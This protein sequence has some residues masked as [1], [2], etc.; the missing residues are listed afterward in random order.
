MNDDVLERLRSQP[1]F[2]SAVTSVAALQRKAMGMLSPFEKH[3]E[4]M[5]GAQRGSYRPEDHPEYWL[6]DLYTCGAVLSGIG[7]MCAL[8]VARPFGLL[9]G[10]GI[11]LTMPYS[12][13]LLAEEEEERLKR[14][15]HE[16]PRVH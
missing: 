12:M 2:A 7:G 9:L 16:P 15:G 1:Q 6:R 14:A 8:P 5:M 13:M 3:Q 4:H 11:I 10:S